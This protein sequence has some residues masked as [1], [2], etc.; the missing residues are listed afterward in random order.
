[1]YDAVT[2]SPQRGVLGYGAIGRQV[3]RLCRALG[4]E[5]YAFTANE[6]PTAESRAHRG[7]NIP[8]LGDAKGEF[9]SKWFHGKTKE[10]LNDFLSQGYDLLVISLPLT[11]L[12]QKLMGE[13]QFRILSKRRTF[14]VN[15]ARGPIVDQDALVQALETGLIRG[16]ALDVTDP[17]PLPADHPLW[18]S[19]NCMIT[20]H[21]SW[22]STHQLGRIKGLL[23][24]NLER[25]YKG[26]ELINELTFASRT[27]HE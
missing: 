6:R 19:K 13:E 24:D 7:V 9:P 18:K 2:N 5:L 4:M 21:V 8:D 26:E 15:I 16:A 22:L 23:A 1:M 17:E 3:G 25:L 11:R 12:S 27:H 14:V 10:A 20:P